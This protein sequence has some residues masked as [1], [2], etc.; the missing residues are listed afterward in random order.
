MRAPTIGVPKRRRASRLLR[1][2]ADDVKKGG[3]P[4]AG[5]RLRKCAMTGAVWPGVADT[6]SFLGGT[7]L[8]RF[9]PMMLMSIVM[10]LSCSA[11]WPVS[12]SW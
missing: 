2:G 8:K 11:C 12:K 9:P 10:S 6:S 1:A 7:A 3:A 5:H 4:R